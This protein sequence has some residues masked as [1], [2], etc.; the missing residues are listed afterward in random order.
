VEADFK[1]LFSPDVIVMAHVKVVADALWIEA[2]EGAKV[3]N[4]KK[5]MVR[6]ACWDMVLGSDNMAYLMG[7][8]DTAEGRATLETIKEMKE[9]DLHAGVV[10]G[11]IWV[12]E[13]QRIYSLE[14]IAAAEASR[15]AAQ[16]LEQDRLD[17]LD[18]IASAEEASW[19]ASQALGLERLKAKVST[20]WGEVSKGAEDVENLACWDAILA[21]D[22][23]ASLVHPTDGRA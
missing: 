4:G 13:Y 6:E 9:L 21:D 23:L 16:A 2:S 12:D 14:V 18:A 17:A 11:A 3:K 5:R 8:G 15:R 7:R 1:H 19:R 22:E 20:L 10:Q